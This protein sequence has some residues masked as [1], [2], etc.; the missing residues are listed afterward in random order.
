MAYSNFVGGAEKRLLGLRDKLRDP[1][2]LKEHG[3][4][5]K[6]FMKPH[7]PRQGDLGLDL[8]LSHMEFSGFPSLLEGLICGV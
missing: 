8:G 6:P 7:H 1:P 5:G 4:D 3:G 2:F